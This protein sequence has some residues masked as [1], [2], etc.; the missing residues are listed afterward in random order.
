MQ[1]SIQ[2]TERV[3][4]KQAAGETMTDSEELIRRYRLIQYLAF[5]M[6]SIDD[7]DELLKLL[8]T[9]CIS[10]TGASFGAIL[11][12]DNDSGFLKVRQ[13]HGIDPEVANAIRFKIGQGVS[14]RVFQEG[15]A[16]LVQDVNHDPGY[17]KV[18]PETRSELAVPM[19]FSGAI[20]GVIRLDSDQPN[21]FKENDLDLLSTVASHAAQLLLRSKLKADLERKVKLQDILISVSHDLDRHYELKDV[22]ETV[23]RQLGDSFGVMRGMLILFDRDHSDE[24]SVHSA[25]NL[26]DE[27]ISRGIYKVGEGVIG[28]AVQTGEAVSVPDIFKE[29]TFLN[30]M[31]I[32]RRKDIPI[33]FIAA[34]FKL[35]GQPAGVIAVEKKFE[36]ADFLK[37]EENMI[38]LV[39]SMIANKVRNYQL[40][41]GEREKLEAENRSLKQE[42]QRQYSSDSLVTKNRK[43]LEILDLVN[44]VA[45]SST[46][47]MILGE[48]GT[49]KEMIARTVHAASSRRQ[50]PFVSVNCAAIPEN[51]LESELFG[52]KKGAFTGA[53]TDKKGKFQLAD[54]GTLFLDEIGDMPMHLQV[55]L[56][57]AIQE[58][59][60]E[61]VGAERKEKI[62][63]R[64]LA[65][66][67]HD[68]MGLI[69][70]GK[71]R[72]DLYYRLNVVEIKLPP[73]R[74]RLDD[75]PF[76]VHHFLE[77][78]AKLHGREVDGITPPAMRALQS[79]AWP[80]NIR[81][82]E[83]VIER[84]IL[85]CRSGKIEVSHLPT[86]MPQGQETG[87][88]AQI[89]ARWIS[90]H[91]KTVMAAGTV[92]QDIIGMVEKELIQQ[93]MLA[94]NRNKVRTADFLGINRNTLRAKMELYGL[95]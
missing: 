48:S 3:D 47:I 6:T 5:S 14:G 15:L 24:L 62:D 64:F 67:N 2:E 84:A 60:V 11:I 18:I 10:L 51:L 43:M 92:W 70:E 25:Y 75:V 87:S 56:L 13:F 38:T 45:D 52:Y 59:E 40:I 65:A 94:N 58:K 21:A 66:T 91:F 37:D 17:I 90:G 26:T 46:S 16:K 71:F 93:A 34:P 32:K 29:K 23:M 57:R 50:A 73:L 83:N 68:L 79:Y 1:R 12:P 39:G 41:S 54:S 69:A 7:L 20:L 72:E 95:E 28:R 44:M 89:I 31:Q 63:V 4:K 78:Y 9:Q 27:E 80:G 53:A 76:L 36:S 35:D 77:K 88:D 22:F 19:A 8:L 81:E 74:D 33:S 61:P 30:R 86:F 82:L 49:G 55:K 42:L 85:L